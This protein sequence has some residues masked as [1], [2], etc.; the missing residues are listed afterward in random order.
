MA[1][2]QNQLSIIRLSRQGGGVVRVFEGD[3]K[4]DYYSPVFSRDGKYLAAADAVVQRI[5]L[6][7]LANYCF[8]KCEQEKRFMYLIIF[9]TRRFGL[10]LALTGG[11]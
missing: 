5:P 11:D 8:G 2:I 10:R 9:Q 1:V 4:D 3:P 6:A 7:Q